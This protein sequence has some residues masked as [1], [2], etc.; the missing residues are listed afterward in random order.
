ML[1]KET[2]RKTCI[3]RLRKASAAGGYARHRKVVRA[4]D[5]V[6][7]IY[8]PKSILLYLPMPH[9]PDIRPLFRRLRK[10]RRVYVPFME[11]KSFKLVQYRLP[12][13]RKRYGIYEPND[14]HFL[15]PKIE[16]AVVP[17]VGV[18]GRFRR[19]GFGKGMYDRFF[20]TLRRKPTTVFVQLAKCYTKETI[21]DDYDVEAD[22]Y[23]T[24]EEITVRGIRHVDRI[25][26]RRCG[27]HR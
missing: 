8:N 27:G 5:R 19:I 9:E 17:V 14:S 1:N 21:T 10:D 24:P 25:D 6:I 2:I 18:D 4:L 3:A 16:M 11:G 13:R 22:I 26:H 12:L 23:I 15:L 7:K 20:A